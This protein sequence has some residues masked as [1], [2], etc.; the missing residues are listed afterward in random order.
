ML[1]I[2]QWLYIHSVAC[3]SMNIR[4]IA[5]QPK[6]HYFYFSMHDY[7]FIALLWLPHLALFYNF[8]SVYRPTR[9]INVFWKHLIVL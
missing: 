1:Q 8:F 6:F 3:R 5:S 7:R 2:G 9:I 4:H